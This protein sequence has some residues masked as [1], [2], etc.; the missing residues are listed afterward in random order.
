MASG[1]AI[2]PASLAF[3]NQIINT[4]SPAQ[5][6][7]LTN[8]GADTLN[9]AGTSVSPNFTY[10]TSCGATVAPGANCGFAVSFLPTATGA[11]T[12]TLTFSDDASGSPHSV[13]LNGTGVAA[14][15][16]TGPTPSGSY[17]ITING[18]AGTLVQGAT[19]TLVVQ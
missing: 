1:V 12:G 19:V 14:P 4:Q 3:G 7:Y 2:F 15:S 17:G 11:L 6:V 9:L 13:G 10:V 18:T 5:L 16:A 8:S